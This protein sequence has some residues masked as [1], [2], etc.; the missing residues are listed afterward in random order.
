MG[1][2]RVCVCRASWSRGTWVHA[3]CRR[4]EGRPKGTVDQWC[5][6]ARFG[7]GRRLARS[8]NC[9][10]SWRPGARPASAG[11]AR[12]GTGSLALAA[13]QAADASCMV[14]GCRAGRRGQRGEGG[15][16]CLRRAVDQSGSDTPVRRA[17]ALARSESFISQ[18]DREC[19]TPAR[20]A[21][22]S[23]HNARSHLCVRRAASMLHGPSRATG[24]RTHQPASQRASASTSA[25]CPSQ[26][27][28]AHLAS[29]TCT[30]V[31]RVALAPCRRPGRCATVDWP[32]RST[33]HAADW[34]AE[35][36]QY[37]TTRLLF[38]T[39][40][41]TLKPSAPLRFAFQSNPQRPYLSWSLSR[42]LS[43]A[44]SS[45]RLLTSPIRVLLSIP[46]NTP[47]T[48]S[49]SILAGP[50]R[51]HSARVPSR[52]PSGHYV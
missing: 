26:A 29:A 43:E 1:K 7:A 50:R 32:R 31:P 2:L 40:S 4:G 15:T 13:V 24:G 42:L 12:P 9:A 3:H 18:H 20:Q 38:H 19:A 48:L 46:F 35:I 16:P 5:T 10:P 37:E 8:G 30:A 23:R 51:A 22:M 27:G 34:R 41:D 49:F 44:G 28:P 6:G 17:G 25:Q 14:V 45:P 33:G 36:D 39:P 11:Q 52:L 47:D 21:C